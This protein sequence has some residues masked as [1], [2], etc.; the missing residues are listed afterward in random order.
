MPS[1]TILIS[2]A[3]EQDVESAFEWYEIGKDGLGKDLQLQLDEAMQS[4]QMPSLK[5]QVRYENVRI[6]FLKKFP[7]GIHYII[8]ENHILVLAVF[9]TAQNPKK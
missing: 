8:N 3:A 9:H 7:Y 6:Y 4:L 1:Y 2:E 5:H